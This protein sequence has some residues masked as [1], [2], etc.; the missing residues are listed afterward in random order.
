MY[1]HLVEK[2]FVFCLQM[3]HMKGEMK[4]PLCKIKL[5]FL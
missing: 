2:D 1:L 5:L 3:K 4:R